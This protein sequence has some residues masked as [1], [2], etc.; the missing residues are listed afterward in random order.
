MLEQQVVVEEFL[1]TA[2][3]ESLWALHD[4]IQDTNVHTQARRNERDGKN[5]FHVLTLD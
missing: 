2:H 1:S 3:S 5:V 4:Q